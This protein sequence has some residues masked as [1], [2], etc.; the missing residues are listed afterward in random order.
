[1]LWEGATESYRFNTTKLLAVEVCQ[2]CAEL[3]RT[4]ARCGSR[5]GDI[6]GRCGR[7]GDIA[8]AERSR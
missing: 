3:D 6:A 4:R 5:C 7:C 1:M 8:C 2:K